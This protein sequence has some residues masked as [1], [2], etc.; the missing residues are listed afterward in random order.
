MFRRAAINAALGSARSFYSHLAKWRK[1]KEKAKQRGR[2]SRT[3]SSPPAYMEQ[4]CHAV[5]GSMERAYADS[6]IVLKVW[7]GACWSWIKVRITGRELPADAE[8]G[9]P[10]LIGMV[11]SGGCILPLRSNSRA[12]AK[13]R[14]KS[15]QT[16]KPRCVQST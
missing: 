7:T 11:I 12:L 14:S 8:M 10:F 15:P 3:P 5:Y 13:S 4:V 16:H 9:S 6:S 1:R 2:N